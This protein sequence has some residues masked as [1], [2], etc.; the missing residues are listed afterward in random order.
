[1]MGE[2]IELALDLLQTLAVALLQ[3]LTTCFLFFPS[4]RG[5]PIFTTSSGL[6]TTHRADP[7]HDKRSC[8]LVVKE[9][10]GNSKRKKKENPVQFNRSQNNTSRVVAAIQLRALARIWITHSGQQQLYSWDIFT[11]LYWPP[12]RRWQSQLRKAKRKT[13]L[14]V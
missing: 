13:G 12:Y 9:K 1:M 7:G 6:I 8:W 14:N 3:S 5:V 4:K 11:G 10:E 2:K